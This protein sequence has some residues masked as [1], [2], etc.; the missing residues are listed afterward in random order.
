MELQTNATGL[1]NGS[2]LPSKSNADNLGKA[3][4]ADCKNGFANTLETVTRLRAVMLSCEV[5]LAELEPDII[6]EV[7]KYGKEGAAILG[8]R[9]EPMEGGVKYQ[10]AKAGDPKWE[11]LKLAADEA[12]AALKDRE[13]FLKALKKPMDEID[14]ETGETAHI[15]PPPKTSKSTYKVT[16]E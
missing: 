16:L 5:A 6:S 13:T 2:L 11:A 1:L 12:A 3:I 7:T 14:M 4:A 8:A 9:I 15:V 10:Y